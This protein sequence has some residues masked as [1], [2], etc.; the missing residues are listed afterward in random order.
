MFFLLRRSWTAS[1]QCMRQMVNPHF[2]L[3]IGQKKKIYMSTSIND[4]YRSKMRLLIRTGEY[5]FLYIFHLNYNLKRS[6]DLY[7]SFISPEPIRD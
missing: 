2:P 1:G 4:S 3:E 6:L 5:F 7:I